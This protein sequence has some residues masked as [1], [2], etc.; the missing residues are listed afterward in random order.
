MTNGEAERTVPRPQQAQKP[1]QQVPMPKTMPAEG[2]PWVVAQQKAEQAEKPAE[3]VP[4]RRVQPVPGTGIQEG[5]PQVIARQAETSLREPE[6]LLTGNT[7]T[8]MAKQ[9]STGVLFNTEG[10]R[11]AELSSHP[12]GVVLENVGRIPQGIYYARILEGRKGEQKIR[13]ITI[14]KTV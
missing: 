14:S 9:N 7:L 5:Q 4:T 3:E 13:F 6:W 2:P 10:E 1:E 11:I 12:S 8:I